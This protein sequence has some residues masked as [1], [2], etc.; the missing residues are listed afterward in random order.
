MFRKT[1]RDYYLLLR[2]YTRT[3]TLEFDNG[4]YDA[5]SQ[6]PLFCSTCTLE[7]PQADITSLDIS[8]AGLIG[9]ILGS[10]EQVIIVQHVATWGC[11]T[12]YNPENQASIELMGFTMAWLRGFKS[13]IHCC[14]VL[15]FKTIKNRPKKGILLG[16]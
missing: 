12:H 6:K 16:C 8:R 2:G 11:Q 5:E 10:R 3:S 13:S 15:L 7:L 1:S 14:R 9:S 4:N